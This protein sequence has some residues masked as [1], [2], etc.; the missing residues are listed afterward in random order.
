MCNTFYIFMPYVNFRL[1]HNKDFKM[2]Q[3]NP[4]F[5]SY[6]FFS[7]AKA[8]PH[9]LSATGS[10]LLGK[11]FP[12]SPQHHGAFVHLP[13]IPL[14]FSFLSSW[15]CFK[16]SEKI[17]VKTEKLLYRWESSYVFLQMTIVFWPVS[18]IAISPCPTTT[19][20]VAIKL[21]LEYN[22]IDVPL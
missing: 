9:G 13:Q 20:R 4:F 1:F 19:T 15:L 17:A 16:D 21:T 14:L 5:Y 8:F 22:Y 10:I 6:N 18:M 12:A 3:T 11:F 7:L 2:L